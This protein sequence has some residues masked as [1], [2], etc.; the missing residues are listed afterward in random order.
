M[1]LAVVLDVRDRDLDT[2]LFFLGRRID[3]CRKRTEL[4][5]LVLRRQDW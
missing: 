1:A 5:R 4:N 2:A 3:P